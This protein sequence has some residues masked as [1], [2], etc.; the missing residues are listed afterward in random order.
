MPETLYPEETRAELKRLRDE[1][2]ALE[3]S[4]PE[5]P[6]AMGVSEG[7]V[8]DTPILHPRQPSDAGHDG[9]RGASRWCSPA[10]DPPRFGATQ[11]GR[12]E[13]ARWLVDRGPPLTSRVMVNRIWRWHFGQGLVATPDNFGALGDRPQQPAAA[14]LAG[15]PLH[16]RAAG[17]S[18]R[19]TG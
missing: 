15:P 14:G 3:K 1:L 13:L 6:S 12:L 4:A 5:M 2:A 8:A 18:R 16:R 19:C 7:Q 9:R 10:T 17:R 11:S